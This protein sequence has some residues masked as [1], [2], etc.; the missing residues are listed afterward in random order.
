MDRRILLLLIGF[1]VLASGCTTDG[2]N[3]DNKDNTEVDPVE[4]EKGLEITDFKTSDT[5]LVPDQRA[6]VTLVLKNYHV[7]PISIEQMELYNLGFLEVVDEKS[8]TPR[9]IDV[10]KKGFIPSMECQWVVKA[11]PKSEMSGFD[12]KKVPIKLRLKYDSQVSNYK[13]ALKVDYRQLTEITNTEDISKTYSNGEAK[14]HLSTENPV[15][16]SESGGGRLMEIKVENAGIG[17]IASEGYEFSY[18]PE[19]VFIH[20]EEGNSCPESKDPVID[21][22]VEFGCMILP[23]V[24]ESVTRNLMISVSYKYVKSPTLDI[25]VVNR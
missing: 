19:E 25:E 18:T 3:G 2:T 24:E 12:S 10:A 6:V 9:E 16:Y 1:I 8:C 7:K 20:E 4:V 23:D 5:E 15:P 13:Q 14:L 11:P 21:D 17:Q 22:T